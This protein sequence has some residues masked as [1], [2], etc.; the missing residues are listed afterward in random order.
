MNDADQSQRG[1]RGRLTREFLGGKQSHIKIEDS[2][3]TDGITNLVYL[4]ELVSELVGIG[5]EVCRRTKR[6]E[7][8]PWGRWVGGQKTNI[9]IS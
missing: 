9:E 2:Y 6:R 1:L 3:W 8:R 4:G 7:N 5:G